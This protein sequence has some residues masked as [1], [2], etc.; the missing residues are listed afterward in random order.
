[1]SPDCS[2][3][4]VR[5]LCSC[6]GLAVDDGSRLAC[7]PARMAI[8]LRLYV[9]WFMQWSAEPGI[10]VSRADTARRRRRFRTRGRHRQAGADVRHARRAG[11]GHRARTLM[12]ACERATPAP[13]AHA[14]F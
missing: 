14:D 2:V 4:V 10:G 11:R 8:R 1:M 9:A 3:Y 13:E 6:R 5:L 7:E 12:S